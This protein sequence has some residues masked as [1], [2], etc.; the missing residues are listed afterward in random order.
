VYAL[1]YIIIYRLQRAALNAR[2]R[3]RTWKFLAWSVIAG[4]LASLLILVVVLAALVLVIGG[5]WWLALALV[6]LFVTPLAEPLVMRHVVAPLGWY[7][8]A[9]WIGH[10]VS[11]EDSDAGALVRAGWAHARKPTPTGEAWIALRRDRR[12]PLGD[13]EVVTTALLAAGRGDAATA[14]Q[15][16]RSVRDMVEVHAPVRELAGEWLAC[17]AVE[18]GAWAE[19]AADATAATWPATSLTY[20][21]EGIALARTG[22][23][24]APGRLELEARWL[25][26]PYRRTTRAWLAPGSTIGERR[27]PAAAPNE[28]VEP[29]PDG[30]APLPRAMAAHLQIAGHVSPATLAYTVEAWDVALADDATRTWLARRALQL[31]APLGA[32]DRAIKDVAR[33]VT[34]E[35]ARIADA[36]ALG[37]PASRGAVGDALARRLRHGR[38]D[39][40]EAGFTHW[41]ERRHAGD[42][43]APIDE[44]REWVALRTAYDAAVAAGGMDLRRLAF[45]HAYRTGSNM[46]AW[47]WNSRSEYA[48]SHAV[49]AWLLGEA[50]AVGDTEAIDL[51]TRNAQLAVQTRTG[52][53]KR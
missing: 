32:V 27:A 24:N 20:L 1:P 25:L 3:D 44:W 30:I 8:V 11:M 46:A 41:V 37:A 40:L 36:A 14:R 51:C 4:L 38:L 35:L 48:L 34:D 12:K 39:A 23:T 50:L 5:W 22:A 15:L 52:R 10:F 9:F 16:M 28:V 47:L 13:A 43:R 26:A 29:A 17:D 45:P 49:S 21:L 19:L 6:A 31:D 2:R 7:R 53:F 42:V 18:R 33:A